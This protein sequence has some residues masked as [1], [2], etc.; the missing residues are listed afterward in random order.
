MQN[1]NITWNTDDPDFTKCFEKTV[2][3]WIPC[4][5]LWTFSSLEVYYLLKSK[6]RNIPWN[7]LNIFKLVVTGVLSII[8]LSDLVN[9]FKSADSD[10]VVYSVDIY[11]P[12]I[13]LFTFVSIIITSILFY[14]LQQKILIRALQK[15]IR[16]KLGNI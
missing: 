14:C 10:H 6:R 4:F 2:L 9:A 11:S 3:V 7:W 13:K 12:L 15:Y 5:F 1:I 16:L 8:C